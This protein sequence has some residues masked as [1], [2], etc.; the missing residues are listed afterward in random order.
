MNW[1]EG[2]LARHSRGRQAK[3]V[4]LRQK[5]H[6]AKAR[7]GLLH[8]ASKRRP[9]P[10]SFLHHS[11][12]PLSRR[13][14]PSQHYSPLLARAS[15]GRAQQA[16]SSRKLSREDSVPAQDV[17]NLPALGR[18]SE[19]DADNG[20][21]EHP[22]VSL[23]E[24][25]FQTKRRKLLLKGDWV[26]VGLQKPIPVKFSS[27]HSGS[28]KWSRQDPSADL[29]RPHLIRS[30]YGPVEA[31]GDRMPTT[32]RPRG[33]KIRIGS[34]E[35]QLGDQFGSHCSNFP[36]TDPRGTPTE[37]RRKIHPL[38]STSSCMYEGACFRKLGP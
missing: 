20:L 21:S 1:T 27:N 36:S 13:S 12:S 29:T 30:R 14:D 34:R 19:T 35:M 15:V 5:E 17:T 37:N 8:S 4:L 16:P 22:S 26:G 24:K 18:C 9:P 38:K 3:Q 6:F 32:P 33:I 2:S 28:L 11:S 10:I 23:T 25:A 7:A 31:N